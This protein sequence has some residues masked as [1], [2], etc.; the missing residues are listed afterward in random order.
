MKVSSNG[1]KGRVVVAKGYPKGS[2]KLENPEL[3][4][5]L[6]LTACIILH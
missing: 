4:F 5:I 3:R 6:E 2:S 1:E